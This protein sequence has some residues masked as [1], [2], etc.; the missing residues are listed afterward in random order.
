M[1]RFHSSLLRLRMPNLTLLTVARA[2]QSAVADFVQMVSSLP[3]LRD[4]S[5]EHVH[6]DLVAKALPHLSALT[7]LD[8]EDCGVRP[9]LLD[10]I[11]DHQLLPR[12]VSLRVWERKVVWEHGRRQAKMR[13]LEK[14]QTLATKIPTLRYLDL[15]HDNAASV[16]QA[17]KALPRSRRLTLRLGHW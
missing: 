9:S 3:R 5:L 13:P 4:L 1:D 14:V 6:S 10:R 17:M 15:G 12:L 11:A 2:P 7:A 16:A 8:I